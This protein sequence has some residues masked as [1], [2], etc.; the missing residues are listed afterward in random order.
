M[1]SDGNEMDSFAWI[2]CFSDVSPDEISLTAD[3][4]RVLEE[5][6]LI[7]LKS[8]TKGQW[9]Q[10]EYFTSYLFKANL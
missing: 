3:S 6:V 9:F 1:T 5:T 10:Y 2:S 4:F 8:A 7:F